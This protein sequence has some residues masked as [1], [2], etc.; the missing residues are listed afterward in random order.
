MCNLESGISG[1]KKVFNFC[2]KAALAPSCLKMKVWRRRAPSVR[3]RILS[4]PMSME[5]ASS[6]PVQDSRGSVR[7]LLKLMIEETELSN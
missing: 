1:S 3:L 4:G 7:M 6:R 2:M 5:S